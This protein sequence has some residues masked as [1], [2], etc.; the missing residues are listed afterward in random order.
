MLTNKP[1]LTG[2]KLRQVKV[3]EESL[4]TAYHAQESNR[5]EQAALGLLLKNQKLNH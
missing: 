4:A 3:G 5:S 1:D 2:N